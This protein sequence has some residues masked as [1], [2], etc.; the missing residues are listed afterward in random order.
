MKTD[1]RNGAAEL[2][3]LFD[4]P[5]PEV[6]VPNDPFVHEPSLVGRVFSTSWG[7]DQTNVEFFTVVRE[8]ESS[9]WLRRTQAEVRD[10]RLW[11]VEGKWRTDIHL[12]GNP[13]TPTRLRDEARG[14]SE[15][16]SRKQRGYQGRWWFR[17]DDSRHA[18]E[19]EGGGEYDTHASGQVGH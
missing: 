12:M 19:Y 16:V 3:A 9:V 8:S 6:H 5:T 4:E 15:K 17:I 13:G 1:F 14:Y 7:Y 11:P 18:S 10:G 2:A